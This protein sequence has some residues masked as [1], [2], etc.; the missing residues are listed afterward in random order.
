[1]A[2]PGARE[3]S[4]QLDAVGGFEFH[5]RAAEDAVLAELLGEEVGTDGGNEDGAGEQAW[6]ERC[7][8]GNC[9]DFVSGNV[10]KA[11]GDL[12]AEGGGA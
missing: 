7:G 5:L 10:G 12:Q 2:V 3:V 1:M 6:F 9:I 11:F 8:E 4:C